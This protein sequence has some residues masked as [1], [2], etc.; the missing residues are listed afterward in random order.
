MEVKKATATA[1]AGILAA[2]LMVGCSAQEQQTAD[3]PLPAPSRAVTAAETALLDRAEERLVSRCMAEAGFTYRE[4]PQPGPRGAADR[5]FPYVV[6]DVAWAKTY[7]YG[8]S[9]TS[10]HRRRATR[11]TTTSAAC[12]PNDGSGAA[13]R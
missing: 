1:A 2:G 6:D 3:A 11:A 13:S 5:E 8:I 4:E 9:A 10:R 7:G 12:R